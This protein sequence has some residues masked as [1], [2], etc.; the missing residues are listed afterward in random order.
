MDINNY[1][2][3]TR[4]EEPAGLSPAYPYAVPTPPNGEAEM[5]QIWG[6][7]RRRWRLMLTVFIAVIAVGTLYVLCRKPVY[8]S[9]A[10][11]T[12]VSSPSGSSGSSDL[13]VMTD[14]QGL[15]RSAS[16]Q[17]HM[18]LI[19][20][21]DVLLTAASQM[22]PADIKKGFGSLIV[23]KWAFRAELADKDSDVIAIAARAYDPRIAADYANAVVNAY[24]ERDQ[25][26]SRSA[27]RQVREYVFFQLNTVQKQLADA[28]RSL[29]MYKRKVNIVAPESQVA[30]ITDN[31]IAVQN[32]LDNSRVEYA[33]RQNE[34][35]ILRAQLASQGEEVQETKTI[36]VN[37]R[38]Q[39]AVSALDALNAR[40]AAMGQDY[41][42][43][44]K[45]MRKLNGEISAAGRQLAR[46]A[47]TIVASTV[48]SRN[49]V[50]TSYLSS[51]AGVEA[52]RARVH[53]L[54][55][56][57]TIHQRRIQELPAF[58][59]ELT[60]LTTRM[61]LLQGIYQDLSQKYYVLLVNENSTLPNARLASAAVPPPLPVAPNMP[62][63]A[64]VFVIL[65]LLAS[66]AAAGVAERLD[67]RIRDDSVPQM[68][69]GEQP[70][71]VIP[72]SD[73]GEAFIEAFRTL[74]NVIVSHSP[75]GRPGVLAITSPGRDEGKRTVC[76]NL[77]VAMAWSGRKVLLVDADLRQ[78]SLAASMNV[79]G[80]VGLTNLICGLVSA[81]EAIHP[82]N[83]KNVYCMPAG[84]APYYPSQFL[85][86]HASLDVLRNASKSFDMVIVNGPPCVGL[87]DIQVVSRAADA[88]ALVVMMDRTSRDDLAGSLQ[89]LFAVNAPYSGYILN[90]V[91]NPK[92]AANYRRGAESVIRDS[93]SDRPALLQGSPE[94]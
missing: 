6:V 80:D 38:Y 42:P 52:A 62:R 2:A 55:R 73:N 82:T 15:T 69:L 37:P 94:D 27:T 45:E 33:S 54:K 79:P 7:V 44:S 41:A 13:R 32:E 67:P 83:V 59:G 61:N 3:I 39:N 75:A 19:G 65:G 29:A 21:P 57:L 66:A 12:V 78:P 23:P 56:V 22:R 14:L 36:Q 46:V 9:T 89:S 5:R 40:K 20:R 24:V 76:I 63:C 85:N 17:S 8:E 4:A 60:R 43:N 64:V 90:C 81:E 18:Q 68:L 16:V 51:L 50:M 87:S 30:A 86:S 35:R 77:A 92:F 49:P 28:Q 26:Y 74:R 70:L 84:P 48:R 47:Q 31:V 91:N 58:E 93:D 10:M 53:A 11:V 25:T 34:L 88:V 71:A 72:H 1:N